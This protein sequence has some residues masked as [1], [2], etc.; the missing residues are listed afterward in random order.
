LRTVDGKVIL[1]DFGSSAPENKKS[2]IE[3]N[4]YFASDAVLLSDNNE[5]IYQA[6][7]DIYSLTFTFIYL[8]FPDTFSALFEIRTSLK[9]ICFE[10][11]KLIMGIKQNCKNLIISALEHASSSNSEYD[12]ARDCIINLLH[13][14]YN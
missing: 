11:K 12:N 3:G 6:S 14:F 1:N 8:L 10:R 7:D 9:D 13:N 4:P 5:H 2:L